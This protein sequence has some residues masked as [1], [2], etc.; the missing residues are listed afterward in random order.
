L[1]KHLTRLY[2]AYRTCYD[3][4]YFNDEIATWIFRHF[5]KFCS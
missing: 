1:T 5:R 3:L 2:H 4:T